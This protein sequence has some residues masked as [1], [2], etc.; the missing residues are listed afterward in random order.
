M[1]PPASTWWRPAAAIGGRGNEVALRS[2]RSSE[3]ESKRAPQRWSALLTQTKSRIG[4]NCG[5]RERLY[6]ANWAAFIKYA[7]AEHKAAFLRALTPAS[8]LLCCEGKID[9]A[10]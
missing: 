6:E 5:M 1:R 2:P 8:G 4:F 7:E 10:P 3:Q 9:G